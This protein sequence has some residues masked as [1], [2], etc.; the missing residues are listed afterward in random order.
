MTTPAPVAAL[1]LREYLCDDCKR[2]IVTQ[3][4]GQ[5]LKCG[6]YVGS[7]CYSLCVTCAEERG[8]CGRCV[9]PLPAGE[10]R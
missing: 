2:C 3:N 8:A 5:C 7:A 9:K 4:V 10:V 1:P 6:G